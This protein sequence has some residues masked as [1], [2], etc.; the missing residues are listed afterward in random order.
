MEERPTQTEKTNRHN[1]FSRLHSFALWFTLSITYFLS[2]VRRYTIATWSDVLVKDFQAD[3]SKFAALS[4]GFWYAY[5][6]LQIPSGIM[7]DLMINRYAAALCV[8]LLL[9]FSC[10]S[11]CSPGAGV[12]LAWCRTG[13]EKEEALQSNSRVAFDTWKVFCRN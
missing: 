5:A 7:L 8:L 6:A 3:A 4:F 12:K 11:R 2:Y 9:L 1:T 13:A 10:F